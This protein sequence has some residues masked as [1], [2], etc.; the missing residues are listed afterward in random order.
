[1]RNPKPMYHL[2]AMGQ[3]LLIQ[4]SQ[5]FIKH[6]LLP[7]FSVPHFT[8]ACQLAWYFQASELLGLGRTVLC[9]IAAPMMASSWLLLPYFSRYHYFI[10]FSFFNCCSIVKSCPT[11]CNAMNYSLPPFPAL[12]SLQEFAQT[13]VHWVSDA[14]QQFHPLLP[15][16]PFTLHLFQHQG[17]FRW[18]SSSHQVAKVLELQLQH[19]IPMSILCWFPLGLTSLISLLSK[20]L[21]RVF[22]STTIWKHQFFSA[23]P[24]LSS[25][26]HIHTWLLENHNFDYMN[27]CQQSNVSAF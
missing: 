20:G 14:I 9:S 1:M 26:T 16:S 10:C 5:K 18:I 25:N 23:Q 2:V 8:P 11:L 12:H 4:C 13:H 7:Y 27:L 19:V 21:T 3:Y 22:T 24:S 17:L 15:S 6:N